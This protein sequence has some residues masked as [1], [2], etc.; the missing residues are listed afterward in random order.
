M[1][2]EYIMSIKVRYFAALKE[3]AKTSE[4]THDA[5][6]KTARALYH[7]LA[8]RHHFPLKEKAVKVAVNDALVSMDHSLC[9]GDSVVFIP[10]VSGG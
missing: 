1:E 6:G 7:E 2:H 10:P 9:D 8:R 5:K 4:E 3:L